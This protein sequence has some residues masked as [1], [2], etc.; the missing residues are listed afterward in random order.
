MRT[1]FISGLHRSGT[2]ILNMIVGSHPDCIAVGE[3]ANVIRA[4]VERSWIEDHYPTCTCG[5]CTFWPQVMEAINRKD[6]TELS[7]RYRIFLE[8]FA[9]RFPGKIAVDSS[10]TLDAL[11][12]LQTCSECSVIRIVRDVRGW[13]YSKKGKITPRLMLSWLRSN[14][15]LER[16]IKD[17]TSIQV[18]YEPLVFDTQTTVER[19]CSRLSLPYREEMLQPDVSRQ[20]ILVGNP[21]RINK[22]HRIKYDSRWMRD[23]S[24]WP[25]LLKPVMDYNKKHAYSYP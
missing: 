23:T 7:E 24:L 12:A 10:K 22:E 4:G 21:M 19:L 9:D 11:G 1:I 17:S 6:P 25:I 20:H 15:A 14:R 3:V 16:A 5:N 8:V 2:T 18:G 13:N